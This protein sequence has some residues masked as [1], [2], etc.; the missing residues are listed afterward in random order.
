MDAKR[1]LS[2]GGEAGLVSRCPGGMEATS[3]WMDTPPQPTCL[4]A[5]SGV[6]RVWEGS[7]QRVV[8]GSLISGVGGQRSISAGP[9][10]REGPPSAPGTAT[11]LRRT[12]TWHFHPLP[13]PSWYHSSLSLQIPP[14]HLL[15]S[16][17]WASIISNPHPHIPCVSWTQVSLSWRG[18]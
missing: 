5:G 1:F 9:L 2:Q 4:G 17:R 14:P 6:G 13:H 12:W 11:W 3:G 15:Y 7:H 10:S 8:N 16:W 18:G